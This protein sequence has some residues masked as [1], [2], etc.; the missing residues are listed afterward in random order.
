MSE[1]GRSD[2]PSPRSNSR[3]SSRKGTGN[4]LDPVAVVH[5]DLDGAREIF[6]IHGWDYPFDGDPLF[7]SGVHGALRL[8]DDLGLRV[9]MFA[10]A[11][12]VEDRSNQRVLRAACEAGHEIASHSHS[13]RPLDGLSQE[14]VQ[15]EIRDSRDRLQDLLGVPIDGFRAPRFSLN[16]AYLGTIADAGY[17]YDSSLFSNSPVGSALSYDKVPAEPH[18]PLEGRELLELPMPAH[19][20]LPFPFHPSYAMVLGN[21]YFRL[22]LE[23]WRARGGRLLVLLFHLTDF[24]TPLPRAAVRGPKRVLYTISHLDVEEKLRRCRYFIES[25][26]RHYEIIT[27][28]QLLKRVGS[29]TMGPGSGDQP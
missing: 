6:S 4:E 29:S 13:H 17:R 16:P 23:R 28:S 19:R 27:T 3:M 25:V 18:R 11:R 21:W 5:V 7:E 26:A 20:P 12:S 9:T 1:S 8:F 22:G 2:D 24:A 14:E 15:V 10:V